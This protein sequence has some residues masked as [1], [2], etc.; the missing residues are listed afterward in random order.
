MRFLRIV[1]VLLACLAS[2][3]AADV[4]QVHGRAAILFDANTGEVLYKKNDTWRTPIASTQKLLTALLVARA[5]NLS[6][7]LSVAKEATLQAPVKL[8]LKESDR[9]SRANL[10]SALLVKSANDVAYALALD[11]AGTVEAFA[12]KMNAEARRLG[13][14][15]SHFVNPNGLPDPAQYSTARDLACIARAAY[16]N[17]TIRDIVDRRAYLFTYASG[18]T[19]LLVNTNR[20]LRGYSF[21]NGMKTGYTDLAGHCLVASG[22][23]GGKD[24]IAVVL[25]SDKAHVWDDAAKLLEYGLGIDRRKFALPDKTEVEE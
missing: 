9:Y 25:K 6:G 2:L 18:Q 24:M 19:K 15:N 13:A 5:G 7:M 8:Y 4:P 12:A 17:P 22:S 16:R 11:N 23:Y 14:K 20:V 1:S 3:G 21:C 10:L